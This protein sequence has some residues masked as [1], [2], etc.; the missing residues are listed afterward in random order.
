MKKYLV[1]YWREKNDEPTDFEVIIEAFNFD[2]AYTKFKDNN[3]LAKIT[4]IKQVT[5]EK[6]TELKRLVNKIEEIQ[7]TQVAFA[8]DYEEEVE[9]MNCRSKINE[10]IK[11]L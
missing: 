2:D 3:R 9:L 1:H 7:D 8:L 4:L 6:L 5:E 10:I 11:T